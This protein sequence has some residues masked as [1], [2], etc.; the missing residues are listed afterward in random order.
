MGPVFA[1]E[2]NVTRPSVSN[3]SV[4]MLTKFCAAVFMV[5]QASLPVGAGPID[6][7]RSRTN[8]I[9]R[10]RRA[11]WAEAPIVIELFANSRLI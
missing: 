7:E 11:D 8:T 9:F 6:P 1:V 2:E 5:G 4:N 10:L 3:P